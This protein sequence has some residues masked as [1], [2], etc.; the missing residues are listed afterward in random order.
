MAER[1]QQGTGRH[2]HKESQERWPHTKEIE[3]RG[4]S[5]QHA[6]QSRDNGSQVGGSH[7]E[8][9]GGGQQDRSEEA[10]LKNREYR[11]EDGEVHHHT[12]TYM[13]QHRGEHSGGGGSNGGG[14][15]KR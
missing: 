8:H 15:R 1:D 4:H 5:G 9:G 14:N 3:G 13:E 7:S 11:G 2:P 10:D 6:S 12:R